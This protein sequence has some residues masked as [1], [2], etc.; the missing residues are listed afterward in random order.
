[1]TKS[2]LVLLTGFVSSLVA[3]EQYNIVAID[4]LPVQ[5]SYEIGSRVLFNCTLDRSTRIQNKDLISYQWTSAQGR[6]IRAS[7]FT[8]SL[9]A[10][11]QSSVDYYC[12]AFHGERLLGVQRVTLNLKGIK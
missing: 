4:V 11:Y 5:D 7:T 9:P 2:A 1:M 8:D 10:Y 6:G 3:L 12:H